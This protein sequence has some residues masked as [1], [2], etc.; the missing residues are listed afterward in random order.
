INV[1]SAKE[2]ATE[3]RQDPIDMN[4]RSD[5][6]WMMHSID[7][8]AANLANITFSGSVFSATSTNTDPN[9]YILETGNPFAN[10]LGRIGNVFPIDANLYRT[11][12]IRMRLGGVAQ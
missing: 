11:F 10:L 1:P 4:E 9:I 2:W 7:Q 8:P 12:A 6:S 5:L 3:V